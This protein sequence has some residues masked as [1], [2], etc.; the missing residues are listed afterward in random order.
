MKGDAIESVSAPCSAGGFVSKLNNHAH[1]LSGFWLRMQHEYVIRQCCDLEWVL[2]I[3][4]KCQYKDET[5]HVKVSVRKSLQSRKH[6]SS[7]SGSVQSL[8]NLLVHRPMSFL[9]VFRLSNLFLNNECFITDKS[10]T[11]TIA[12]RL[13]FLTDFQVRAS[14]ATLMTRKIVSGHC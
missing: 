9:A 14:F 13:A 6:L 4:N 8:A 1:M 3:L 11:H 5:Y 10:Q 12:I 2:S 7:F